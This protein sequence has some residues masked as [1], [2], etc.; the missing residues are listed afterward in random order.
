MRQLPLLATFALL[1][2]CQRIP[3]SMTR[4]CIQSADDGVINRL[5]N[6]NYVDIDISNRRFH[7]SDTSD[8]IE[9]INQDHYFGMASPLPLIVMRSDASSSSR[10]ATQFGHAKHLFRLTEDGSQAQA[11]RMSVYRRDYG[12]RLQRVLTYIYTISDGIQEIRTE[13]ALGMASSPQKLKKCGGK[14]LFAQP[15]AK[16]S[17]A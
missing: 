13:V 1:A 15:D 14:P 5:L 9:V 6:K 3:D 8:Q 11:Y 17:T 10:T 7:A 16:R 12:G 4:F 2:A